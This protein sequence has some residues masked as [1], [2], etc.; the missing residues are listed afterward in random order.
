MWRISSNFSVNMYNF[1][2]ILECVW[3]KPAM[4]VLRYH[5]GFT[6][7]EATNQS[8]PIFSVFN[9]TTSYLLSCFFIS[10]ISEIIWAG[11]ILTLSLS[12]SVSSR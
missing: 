5:F 7:H 8:T 10:L 4:L 1:R 12:F 9:Q 3:L 6:S 2:N 11:L